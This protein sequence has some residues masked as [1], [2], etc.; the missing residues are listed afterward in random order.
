M[1]SVDAGKLEA[2]AKEWDDE[3]DQCEPGS[4]EELIDAALK[5]WM[6]KRPYSFSLDQHLKNPT[7][8]SSG[9]P[10]QER[11]MRCVADV[12]RERRKP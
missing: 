2:L 1:K 11:L 12:R 9:S 4:F 10:L 3:A 7:V 5:W 8:N 6:S